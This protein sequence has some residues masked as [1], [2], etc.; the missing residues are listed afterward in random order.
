MAKIQIA[1]SSQVAGNCFVLDSSE[2]DG[3]YY[4][5]PFAHLA[6]LAHLAHH[7]SVEFVQHPPRDQGMLGDEHYYNTAGANSRENRI[8]YAHPVQNRLS[9]KPN[10][11]IE[12][13]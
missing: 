8:A 9:I 12:I 7:R 3:N 1:L 11:Q 4:G 13:A 5:F 2:Y 10:L 6:H